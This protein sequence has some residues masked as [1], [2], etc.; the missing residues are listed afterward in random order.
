MHGPCSCW[1]HSIASHYWSCHFFNI[2]LHSSK[3]NCTVV[4]AFPN[5]L[6]HLSLVCAPTWQHFDLQAPVSSARCAQI[7][8]Q[9]A[10]LPSFIIIRQHVLLHSPLVQYVKHG[11]VLFVAKC[12]G[13]GLAKQHQ[14]A[15]MASCCWDACTGAWLPTLQYCRWS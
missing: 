6:M 8:Y 3:E 14:H 2:I 7:G 15:L 11:T 5:G 13:T 4:S 10:S 9:V 12:A 1:M